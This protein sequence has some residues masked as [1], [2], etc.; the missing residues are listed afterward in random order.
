MARI[1]VAHSYGRRHGL[2]PKECEL[3]AY[4]SINYGVKLIEKGHNPFIPNLYHF[5]WRAMGDNSP[6][7]LTWLDMVKEWLRFCDAILI[8]EMPPY[9]NSGVAEEL[10]LAEA[11]GLKIYRHIDEVPDL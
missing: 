10:R 4:K 8:A 7:E 2:S 3:N 6:P 9:P 5:V 11:L 1:Y